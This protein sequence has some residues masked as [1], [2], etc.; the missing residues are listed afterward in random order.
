[1]AERLRLVERGQ[2]NGK[3]NRPQS[4]ATQPDRVE[5]EISDIAQQEYARPS[6]STGTGWKTTIDGFTAAL[7]KPSASK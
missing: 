3:E 1:M 4:S 5:T 7:S 2:E 6:I